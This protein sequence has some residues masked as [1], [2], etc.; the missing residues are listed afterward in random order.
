MVL[1]FWDETE[2]YVGQIDGETNNVILSMQHDESE[3]TLSATFAGTPEKALE[4]NYIGFYDCDNVLQLF[5][6]KGVEDEHGSRGITREIS[7]E[8][9]VYELLD[10][11]VQDK[12]P[13]NTSAWRAAETA[14]NGTRW[15]VGNICTTKQQSVRF[16]Y[17]DVISCLQKIKE[18]WG[19]CYRFRVTLNGSAIDNRY[20]DIL[21]R[22][23]SDTGRRF[24]WSRNV[25]SIVRTVDTTGIITALYGRGKGVEVGITEA[26]DPTYGRRLNFADVVWSKASGTP[27]DKPKGQEYVADSGALKIWGRGGRHRYGV[28]VFGDIEDASE[29]LQATWERLPKLKNPVITYTMTVIDL[30]RYTGYSADKVRL[31]DTVAVIDDGFSPAL[32]IKADVISIIRDYIN[33]S[34]TR[35]TLG[36]VR[37]GLTNQML[38]SAQTA[39]RLAG[40]EGAYDSA[41][42]AFVG[43]KLPAG[44]LLGAIDTMQNMLVAS[45]TYDGAQQISGGYLLENPDEN[46]PDYGALYLGP[47]IM[48]LANAKSEG[49][50]NW[51]SFGTG[52]G[53]T[54]DEIV[55]G[56]LRAATGNTWINMDDG[57]FDFADGR[58]EFDGQNFVLRWY[59]DA[60]EVAMEMSAGNAGYNNMYTRD[61]YVSGIFL[62]GNYPDKIVL[63]SGDRKIGKAVASLPK[64][65]DHDVVIACASGAQMQE[66]DGVT[67]SG[68]WGPGKISIDLGGGNLIGHI[69]IDGGCAE[70]KNGKI[71]GTQ[72]PE[73]N[74]GAAVIACKDKGR[75]VCSDLSV[76]AQD[77]A[78]CYL[79]DG[80]E[81][82]LKNCAGYYGCDVLYAKNTGHISASGCK[83][84]GTLS[85]ATAELGIIQLA[86]CKPGGETPCSGDIISGA[87][88]TVNLGNPE[89]QS[90]GGTNTGTEQ[91]YNCTSSAHYRYV[92]GNS[93]GAQWGNNTAVSDD[94]V[95]QGRWSGSSYKNGFTGCMWF[96]GLP[97]SGTV[98]SA[99]LYL[100]RHGSGGNSGATKIKLGTIALT[101]PSGTPTVS[102]QT[103]YLDSFAWG[104]AKWIDVP[105][106]IAQALVN[107]T[108]KGLCLYDGSSGQYCAFYG[109]SSNSRPIL[110]IRF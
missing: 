23:G 13:T 91:K 82:V 37:R 29:L 101:G 45:G 42:G 46:S 66:S 107:G 39:Q 43:G 81:M 52:R 12:R 9:A 75:I 65:L 41:A 3:N 61:L 79:A 22:L 104:Q 44:K 18:R 73:Y 8:H 48:A 59:N 98:K 21:P 100:K 78:V 84:S 35:I 50:W 69:V 30:E 32:Q 106:N 85:G 15:K 57:T 34:Q 83:G 103:G 6:I 11:I 24:E 94:T 40:K 4:G 89:G 20:I 49:Q 53:F 27:C 93:A 7:A 92:P 102:N 77:K 64:Y 63:T 86:S 10:D 105:V 62:A 90:P 72:Q 47:G 28:E 14:L 76:Y 19:V 70:L 36:N 80:G 95:M 108:A 17:E 88:V 71:T 97:S 67:L 25:D 74:R 2:Q 109:A 58:V 54:A 26:G 87:D 1:F 60:G 99:Q 5:E 16:Y 51:R 68:F 110:K 31:G 55:T 38:E 56:Y 96:S 33:P